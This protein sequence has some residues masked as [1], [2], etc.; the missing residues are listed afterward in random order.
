MTPSRISERRRHSAWT[1]WRLTLVIA[2]FLVFVAVVFAVF[3][4]SADAD[5]RGEE[6]SAIARAKQEAGLTEI[7]GASKHVWEESVW[8]V[9]GKDAAA[10]E[11]FVWLREDGSVKEK[12]EDGLD[13]AAAAARFQA[14]HPGKKIVRQLPG[15]FAGQPAWEIRYIDDPASKRQ[16]ILFYSFK[17]GSQLK[18]YSLIG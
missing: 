14:D 7:E 9:R 10:T 15:W 17:D 8:V 4:R 3:V 2:G 13:E 5:Y 1:G 12:A 6:R 16:A 18:T 11:W